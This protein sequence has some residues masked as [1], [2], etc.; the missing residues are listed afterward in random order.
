MEFGSF[1]EFHRREG[2]TFADAFQE[3]FEHIDMAEELGLDGV[4]LSEGHFNPDRTVLSSPHSIAAAIEEERIENVR[5]ISYGMIRT[6]VLCRRCDAHLGH[7]FED[8]PGPN[9]LRYCLNS[10]SLDLDPET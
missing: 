2:S 6:E 4:W 5:D 9:G 10:A 1:V 8:G 7:V 3:S